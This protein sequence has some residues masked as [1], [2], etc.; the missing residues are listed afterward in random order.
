MRKKCIIERDYN[1]MNKLCEKKMCVYSIFH[2]FYLA[3]VKGTGRGGTHYD[4]E[5]H[6]D[7]AVINYKGYRNWTRHACRS[8]ATSYLQDRFARQQTQ[9]HRTA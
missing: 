2:L 4:H 3:T 5:Q 7:T 1:L 6:L 9:Q 8:V